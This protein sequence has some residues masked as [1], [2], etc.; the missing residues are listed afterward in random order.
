MA[1]YAS[2]SVVRR[3]TTSGSI[4]RV[5]VTYAIAVILIRG[6]FSPAEIREV[7]QITERLAA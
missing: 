1:G 3:S 2:I 4:G 5:G 7:L 6:V